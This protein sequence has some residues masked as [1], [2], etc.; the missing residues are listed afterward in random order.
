MNE[1]SNIYHAKNNGK[2]ESLK[3]GQGT[4]MSLIM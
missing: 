3:L 2:K 4:Q 1:V